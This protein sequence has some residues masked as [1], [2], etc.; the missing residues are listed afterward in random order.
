MQNILFL[1]H[2]IP[3]PPN[4]GDKIRSFHFLKALSER[5]NVF[6]ATF[7]DDEQDWQHRESLS[8][9]C[10]DVFCLP[11]QPRTAK[12]RSLTGLVNG[13]ALS[14]PY[15]H[16]AELQ[17]WVD[18]AIDQYG[19]EKVMIFS[20]VMGQ[21]V[22]EKSDLK[23]VADFV[24]VDSDKWRQYAQKKRWPESWIYRREAVKLLSYERLLARRAS[25]SAFVSVQEAEL[26]K[27]LAPECSE[28]VTAVN[29]GVDVD[30]FNPAMVFPTPYHQVEKIMV[31]TGAMDY[32]A[33]VD[34]VEWFAREVL[35]RILRQIPH[36]K[37]YIV[38]SKPAKDV[39]ALENKQS[40]FVTGRVEDIRPFLAHASIAIAPLRI[41]RGIQNKVL[42]AMAMEKTVLA[43]SPAM[44]GIQGYDTENV[45]VGDD[46]EQM[47][48]QA[49]RLLSLPPERLHSPSN[50]S[51]VESNFSWRS[52]G[53]YLIELMGS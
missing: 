42:E 45:V 33:N 39:R 53:D 26:F 36:A 10:R 31:F 30:Y 44:E 1:V 24:D 8:A 20:S 22:L 34:A 7:V 48:E 50:R 19:I 28:K 27:Q 12:I 5:F 32:W 6:L 2:R 16:N 9:Y 11:L 47:A 40:V 23:I 37:L 14:L 49:C 43:T 38:G 15:Y 21:Y 25:I 35:P 3:F 41:A 51:F 18:R 4:K 17:D 13:K 46:C 29:N 52:S